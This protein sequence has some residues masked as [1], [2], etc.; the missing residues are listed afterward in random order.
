MV[1]CTEEKWRYPATLSEAYA[2]HESSPKVNQVSRLDYPCSSHATANAHSPQYAL[3]CRQQKKST[4]DEYDGTHPTNTSSA[5][6]A[7]G[8]QTHCS[9]ITTVQ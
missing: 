5:D 3:S 6:R 4:I 1:H 9:H 7:Y 2:L 8:T